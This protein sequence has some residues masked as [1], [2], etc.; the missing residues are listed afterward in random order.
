VVALDPNNLTEST[1]NSL[2]DINPTADGT[3]TLTFIVRCEE[4]HSSNERVS[5]EFTAAEKYS[6]EESLRLDLSGQYLWYMRNIPDLHYRLSAHRLCFTWLG[7][8][9]ALLKDMTTIHNAC[10]LLLR[11]EHKLKAVLSL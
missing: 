2:L 3:V 6:I 8:A 5:I 9:T 7:T 11:N 10:V 4:S 1:T